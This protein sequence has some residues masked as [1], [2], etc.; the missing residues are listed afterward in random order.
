LNEKHRREENEKEFKKLQ[1]VLKEKNTENLQM[2]R[3][4]E[5][6]SI[7]VH[8]KE[9]VL[10]NKRL[11]T[12]EGLKDKDKWIISLQDEL[13]LKRSQATFN[14]EINILEN[15]NLELNGKMITCEKQINLSIAKVKEMEMFLE[16]R[17]KERE[18][19]ADLKRGLIAKI[20]QVQF[21]I[22]EQ[23]KI[24][25]LEIQKKVKEKEDK[26]KRDLEKEITEVKNLKTVTKQR[27]EVK[28]DNVREM[29]QEKMGLQQD[30]MALEQENVGLEKE[31]KENKEILVKLKNSKE[32]LTQEQK[33]L[34]D[35]LQ[36]VVQDNGKMSELIP[37]FEE[38]NEKTKEQIAHMEKLN[39][40]SLQIKNV[41]LEELKL[42]TQ[43]NDQVQNT[44]SDLMRKWDFLQK[45]GGIGKTQ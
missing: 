14:P 45:M 16:T 5:R 3:D 42:L 37:K 2:T 27:Q 38:E 39:E 15:E 28:E 32:A 36:P 11:K 41:N 29:T 26:E 23:N 44:I 13:E 40:L 43:S 7:L 35:K 10:K 33:V 21:M 9:E 12:V 22:E 6:E 1:A 20:A 19:E 31:I 8:H 30:I 25:E 34:E 24:N 4:L 18:F 17:S